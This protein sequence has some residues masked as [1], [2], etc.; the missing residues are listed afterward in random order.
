MGGYIRRILGEGPPAHIFGQAQ[1]K[2]R[3]GEPA[4]GANLGGHRSPH[5][6]AEVENHMRV[7]HGRGR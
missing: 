5:A 2:P 4:H 6:R 7:R 3:L 1:T